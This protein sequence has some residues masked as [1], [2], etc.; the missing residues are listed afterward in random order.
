MLSEQG[1][2]RTLK[3]LALRRSFGG[4][5]PEANISPLGRGSA[6]MVFNVSKDPIPAH[7]I[8]N[9]SLTL[10]LCPFAV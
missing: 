10:K 8:P 7:G 2:C 5:A 1:V 6:P 3:K 4:E 9:R